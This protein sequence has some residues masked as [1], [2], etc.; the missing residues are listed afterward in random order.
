M[1]CKHGVLEQET[2]KIVWVFLRNLRELS[3]VEGSGTRTLTPDT[4]QVVLPL[5][6][7]LPTFQQTRGDSAE[8]KEY[9]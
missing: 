6:A 9:P 4:A 8:S 2:A 1:G 3:P 5:E 7:S